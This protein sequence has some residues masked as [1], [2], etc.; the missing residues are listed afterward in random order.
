M[1]YKLKSMDVDKTLRQLQEI[2]KSEICGYN[3]STFISFESKASG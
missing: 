1:K 2:F 3:L